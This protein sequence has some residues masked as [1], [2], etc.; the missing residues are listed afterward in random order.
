MVY[1][2]SINRDDVK[3][4]CSICCMD[5]K[6]KK[7]VLLSCSH[8][9]H[10]QCL[11]SFERHSST[12]CCPLC[13]AKDYEKKVINDGQ[14]Y[15][16]QKCC[17]LIQNT[18]RSFICLKEYRKMQETIEPTSPRRKE[19][20]YLRKFQKLNN[21][22]ISDVDERSYN[23]DVFLSSIDDCIANSRAVF[24]SITVR[25]KKIRTRKKIN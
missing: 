17:L 9:F 22:L 1:Q 24:N 23:I 6:F 2:Q 8:T 16:T 11:L 20:F 19:K 25:I 4:G 5:F 13:R 21:N 18:W 10:H 14:E 3:Y 15:W 7:Q 12:L